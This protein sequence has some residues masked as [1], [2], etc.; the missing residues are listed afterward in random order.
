MVLA[1]S[2]KQQLELNVNLTAT[3]KHRSEF[4]NWQFEACV[5]LVFLFLCFGFKPLSG[6][7]DKTAQPVL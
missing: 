6:C 1:V 7:A 5:E 3:A 2:P 4:L